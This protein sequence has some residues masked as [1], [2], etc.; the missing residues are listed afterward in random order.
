MADDQ[1]RDD[2]KVEPR[3]RTSLTEPAPPPPAN[4]G[5]NPVHANDGLDNSDLR[6]LMALARKKATEKK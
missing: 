4:K 6:T 5:G 3:K 2:R 1:K